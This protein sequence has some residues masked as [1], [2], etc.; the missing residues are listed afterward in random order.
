MASKQQLPRQQPNS[1][2]VQTLIFVSADFDRQKE[3]L[4]Q[5]LRR[6]YSG[7]EN[8]AKLFYQDNDGN[9]IEA[10]QVDMSS[11]KLAQQLLDQTHLRF[12]NKV[13]A[14]QTLPKSFIVPKIG[15]T[16]KTEQI[17]HNLS[18]NYTGIERI[19]RFYN[20][21]MEP[22]D[23]IRIDFKSDSTVTKVTND[24][25]IF[26]NGKRHSIQPYRALINASNENQKPVANGS[27]KPAQKYLTETR[28][29]ELFAQQ[30]M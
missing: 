10:I 12:L 25:Y 11:S 6:H 23:H 7:V 28:V 18:H 30:Q 2:S 9:C 1:S 26:I 8:V 20:E 5:G 22:T 3:H 15:S 24:G 29:K 21:N 14:M 16:E 13:Y 4:L 17:L 27:S 19:S